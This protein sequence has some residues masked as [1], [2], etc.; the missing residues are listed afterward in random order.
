MRS[1]RSE[2][3]RHT[4]THMR[5]RTYV[6]QMRQVK[7][8]AGMEQILSVQRLCVRFRHGLQKKKQKQSTGT[9]V[10]F[11]FASVLLLLFFLC[12]I[13]YFIHVKM[14]A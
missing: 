1:V 6:I 11:I 2:Y 5:S 14:C 3:A 4:H 8:M 7:Q 12:G 9:F 10:R 13:H